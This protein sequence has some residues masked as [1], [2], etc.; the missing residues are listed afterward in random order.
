[1]SNRTIVV[2]SDY[3]NGDMTGPFRAAKPS[4]TI[5]D[6]NGNVISISNAVV[7]KTANY[8]LATTDYVVLA[9]ASSANIVLTLPS[10]ASVPNKIYIL[11]RIDSGA[12]NKSVTVTSSVNI[13]NQTSIGL[14][15]YASFYAVS[16]NSK[17]WMV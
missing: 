10:A 1:M 11:K 2:A 16:Y 12:G 5:V 3:I 6:A 9:D 13:D 17:W 14:D 7:S 4:D 8:E 15:A